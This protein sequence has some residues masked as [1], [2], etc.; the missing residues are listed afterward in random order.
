[1]ASASRWSMALSDWLD[2]RIWRDGHEYRMRFVEGGEPVA[3]LAAVGPQDERR[4]T[5]ITFMPSIKVFSQTEFSYEVLEHRLRE[6]AFLNSGVRIRLADH[7]LDPPK[8][9]VLFYEGGVEAFV[10][11]LDR[12]KQP[13]HPPIVV[14]TERDRI[15]VDVA[16]Q[17]NDGYHETMLS[18][19][20]NIPQRDGGTH[21]MGFRAALT[22]ALNKFAEE[23]GTLKRD[24]VT[25]TGE[26]MREGLT[27]VLS[28]KMPDPKFSSQTKDKL[29]SSEVT[30]VV[31]N[32]IAEGLA[33]WLETHPV[34]SKLIMGKVVEAATAREA[35]RKARELTRRKGALGHRQPAGQARRLPGARPGQVR[36]VHRRGRQRR[37]LGQAGPRPQHPGDPP[38]ARQDPQRR[39]RPARQGAGQPGDRHPD[40][41]A[42]HRHPRRLRHRQAALPQ[43]RHHD[44]RRRRRLAHPHA[45]AHLLLPPPRRGHRAGPSLHRPAAA[46]SR[47]ARPEGALPQGR[48]GPR[49]VPDRREPRRGAAGRRGGNGR[50]GRR[51]ARPGRAGAVVPLAVHP[52]RPPRAGRAGRGHGAGRRLRRADPRRPGPRPRARPARGA[53]AQR[54]AAR[55]AGR[56]IAPMPANWSST[57]SRASAAS[58]SASTPPSP[59]VP[60]RGAPP[61]SWPR[62]ARCSP[63]PPA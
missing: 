57:S 59:A 27:C 11:Y 41:R 46:L 7:R 13:L 30:P 19:T 24:K 40:H 45:A 14:A 17:W 55:A 4:G 61:P 35:A 15:T 48:R 38:L 34:E 1:M 32:V 43:D 16:L 28:V 54:R 33:L 25:L 20:N 31:S 36:A 6:L 3:P 50:R 18:F 9:E 47:Q 51:A 42:G 23:S 63:A 2:L 53:H 29:V 5:E 44:R 8:E 37:R 62:S 10:R 26:D 22:R 49:G 39:A 12:T 58:A 52:P 60:T 56:R 21:L